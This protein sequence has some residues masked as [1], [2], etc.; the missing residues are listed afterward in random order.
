[1]KK[2]TTP[3]EQPVSNTEP[4]GYAQG[5]PVPGGTYI[6]V[7]NP[8]IPP[9][10][11]AEIE[12]LAA[13]SQPQPTAQK[14]ILYPGDEGYEALFK[15]FSKEKTKKDLLWR[16]GFWE[17]VENNGVYKLIMTRPAAGMDASYGQTSLHS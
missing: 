15:A 14:T 4:E 11:R 17:M 8:Y 7:D 16:G 9:E 6:T 13:S 2:Q 10:I 12:A 5:G 3:A 1:M